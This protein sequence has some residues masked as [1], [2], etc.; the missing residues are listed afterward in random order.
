MNMSITLCWLQNNEGFATELKVLVSF[1]SSAK[2]VGK[3]RSNLAR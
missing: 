1:N 3:P 2:L